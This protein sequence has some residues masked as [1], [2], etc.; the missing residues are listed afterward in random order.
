MMLQIKASDSTP[1]QAVGPFTITIKVA[2]SPTSQIPST[3][4]LTGT[5]GGQ[6]SFSP[7]PVDFGNIVDGQP[8]ALQA[9]TVTN[10]GDQSVTVGPVSIQASSPSGPPYS[11]VVRRGTSAQ[12]DTCSS[13][14]AAGA[15]CTMMLQIKASDSTPGQAVGPF[16]ITIKAPSNPPS[17][18]SATLL[19][20]G[21]GV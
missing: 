18:I 15:T 5:G 14:V 3:L 1:G 4:Q 21:T 11:F 12:G 20:T 13:S 6:F 7:S 19:L 17:Q 8:S 16:T 9:V 2:S 10:L